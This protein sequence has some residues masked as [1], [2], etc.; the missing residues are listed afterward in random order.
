MQVNGDS[1][2][3]FATINGSGEEAEIYTDLTDHLSGASVVLNSNNEVV[4]TTDYY[5]FG[6]IRLDNPSSPAGSSGPAAFSEQRKY[7]G[8]EY[9]EDTG[10]NYLNARYYNS[11]I[12]RFVTQDPVFWNFDSSWLADPQNQNAYAYA[13]NNPITFSDPSGK[14]M[15][16]E[17]KSVFDVKGNYIGIHT[18]FKAVPNHP[19]EINIQG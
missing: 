14:T 5:S 3:L 11:A 8:Q 4:E 18:Y 12:A 15:W 17:S 16:I 2:H 13:R 7:I 10:L 1:Y 19:D 6:Q 9:D